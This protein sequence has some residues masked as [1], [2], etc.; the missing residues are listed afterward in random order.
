MWQMPYTSE[1]TKLL[2]IIKHL[3]LHTFHYKN[4]RKMIMQAMIILQNIQIIKKIVFITN[5]KNDSS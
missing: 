3:T 1:N 4:Y 2:K 5:L